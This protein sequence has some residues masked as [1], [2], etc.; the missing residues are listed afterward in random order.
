MPMVSATWRES[1]APEFRAPARRSRKLSDPG[2]SI[3]HMDATLLLIA[4]ITLVAGAVI[5]WLAASS[6]G[7]PAVLAVQAKLQAAQA[8]THAAWAEIAALQATLDAERAA[9]ADR[10]VAE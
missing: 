1:T 8:E 2:V 9:A 6:R 4:V 7:Q 5:G 10:A 3:E